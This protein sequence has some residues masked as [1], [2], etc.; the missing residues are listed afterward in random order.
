MVHAH[1]SVYTCVYTRTLHDCAYTLHVYTCTLQCVCTC[2]CACVCVHVY[3][4]IEITYSATPTSSND[5]VCHVHVL[6]LWAGVHTSDRT[7]V[8]PRPRPRP[9]PR[10]LRHFTLLHEEHVQCLGPSL[11]LLHIATGQVRSG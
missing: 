3:I 8:I 6:G 9:W 4:C 11:L 10:P 2:V 7:Q 1:Y 5:P